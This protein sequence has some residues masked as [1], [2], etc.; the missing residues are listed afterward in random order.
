MKIYKK[1]R[2]SAQ[3]VE[4]KIDIKHILNMNNLQIHLFK[5]Q[6]TIQMNLININVITKLMEA[7]KQRNKNM[8]INII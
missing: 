2:L 6:E 1:F 4:A 7:K 8:I 3:V 5:I